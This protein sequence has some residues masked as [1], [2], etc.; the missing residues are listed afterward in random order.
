MKSSRL[1]YIQHQCIGYLREKHG[2]N[3]SKQTSQGVID[4]CLSKKKKLNRKSYLIS[5]LHVFICMC[6]A[7]KIALLW[8]EEIS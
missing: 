7:A 4:G 8:N 2:S 3:M 1:K 5:M 6:E